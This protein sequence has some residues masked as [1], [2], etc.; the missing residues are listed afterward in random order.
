MFFTTRGLMA[1][2]SAASLAVASPLVPSVVERNIIGGQ[3]VKPDVTLLKDGKVA[4]ARVDVDLTLLDEPLVVVAAVDLAAKVPNVLDLQTDVDVG[5]A[6]ICND[7]GVHGSIDVTVGVDKPLPYLEVSIKDF[8]AKLDLEVDLYAG[9]YI[10]LELFKPD[11]VIELNLPG[12][13]DVKAQVYL[14]LILSAELPISAGLGAEISLGK[15]FKITTNLLEEAPLQADVDGTYVKL[16]P[17]YVTVGCAKV[18]AFLRLRVAAI[19]GLDLHLND[20]LPILPDVGAGVALAVVAD[21]MNLKLDLCDTP[22]CPVSEEAWGIDVGVAIDL[23]VALN[24]VSLVHLAPELMVEVLEIPTKTNCAHGPRPTGGNGNGNGGGNG[25]DNNGS[26]SAPAASATASKSPTDGAGNGSGNGGDN[27]APGAGAGGDP[28]GAK[29]QPTGANGNGNGNNG[30][31]NGNGNG[32]D[33]GNGNG[34]GSDNGNGNGNGSDNGNG[35]GNGSGNNGN[36]N[37]SDNGNNGSGNGSNNGGNGNG[38]DNGNGSGNNGSGNGNGGNGSPSASVT[39]TGATNAITNGPQQTYTYVACPNCG[40]G[41]KTTVT[42]TGP[43]QAPKHPHTTEAVTTKVIDST[44][45]VPCNRTTVVSPPTNYPAQPTGAKYPTQQKARDGYAVAPAPE[46]PAQPEQPKPT[47]EYP[48]QPQQPEQPA[49]PETTV[50]SNSPVQPTQP[51]QPQQPSGGYQVGQPP[52]PEQPKQPEQPTQPE[53]P[54]QPAQP[55]TTVS[56]N[57]PV[58]PTQPAQPQQPGGGYQVGQPPKPEQPEQP[59]AGVSS[60]SPP[61]PKTSEQPKQPAQPTGQYPAQPQQPKQETSTVSSNSPVQP[62]QPAQPQQPGGQYPAQP[63]NNST[64]PATGVT[65]ST[66]SKPV[67]PYPVTTP[68]GAT[69]TYPAGAA[70]PTTMKSSPTPGSGYPVQSP[71]VTA[72]AAGK[73]GSGFLAIAAAAVAFL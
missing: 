17:I 31:G 67:A 36:G 15:E 26:P 11:Q 35:N 62:T 21:V 47:G 71:V 6:V 45:M 48:A 46:Q 43:A 1:A 27:G 20:L 64:I 34:N 30:N 2:A 53:Q 25:G 40:A 52:K 65:S 8:H 59:S 41:S 22:S 66:V 5:L 29:P 19:V 68:A 12:L 57:S 32:S 55:E 69:Q 58:Q 38:S 23:D 33:N 3:G 61:A 13:L 18:E 4:D 73:V 10:A 56:S 16:L 37:G 44:V 70:Q 63:F 28:Y 39:A 42:A 50:S 9:A 60:S 54:E 49:Q 7:C 24:D 51:A 14:D 72:G